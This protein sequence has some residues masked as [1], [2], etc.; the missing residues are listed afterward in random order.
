MGCFKT[1]LFVFVISV[2]GGITVVT[3][4]RTD[5]IFFPADLPQIFRGKFE[6]KML[7]AM[8]LVW[9]ISNALKSFAELIIPVFIIS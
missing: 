7:S 5:K 8:I 2:R 6:Q 9:K 3:A 4:R 1:V